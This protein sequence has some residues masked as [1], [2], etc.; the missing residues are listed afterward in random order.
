MSL[1]IANACTHESPSV[2]TL[3]LMSH[4]DTSPEKSAP[5]QPPPVLHSLV[6]HP[7]SQVPG[8]SDW[9]LKL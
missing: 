9:L 3:P 5:L 1:T 8:D 6:L 4:F 7:R 2:S